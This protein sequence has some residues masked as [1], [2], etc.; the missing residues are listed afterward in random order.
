MSANAN[1]QAAQGN[2][3]QQQLQL[4]IAPDLD[5]KYRD[6]FNTFIGPEEVVVEFG[7]RHRSVQNAATISDRVVL[8]VANA[9]R[10]EQALAQGL[11]EYRRRIES[12]QQAAAKQGDAAAAN[13]PG[14]SN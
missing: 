13:T 12:Q 3:E 10:L 7:N 1:P 2:Q 6:I 11:A 5:Y 4:H 9:F 8:S 14:E